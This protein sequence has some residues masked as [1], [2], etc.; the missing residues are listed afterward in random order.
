MQE[1]DI[2]AGSGIYVLY[3]IDPIKQF[4]TGFNDVKYGAKTNDNFTENNTTKIIYLGKTFELN[5]RIKQHLDSED[6]SPYLL[7]W[8]HNNRKNILKDA[9]LFV[10]RL[11]GIF[12]KYRNVILS[13]IESYL[14]EIC[15]PI[16]GSRRV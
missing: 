4:G 15:K 14:H 6:T 8:N 11:K 3:T 10:F 12:E 5:T 1:D 16:L 13:T 2:G 9:M 7:K